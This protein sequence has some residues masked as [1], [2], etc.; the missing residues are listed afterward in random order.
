MIAWRRVLAIE[1]IDDLGQV[2]GQPLA[3]GFGHAAPPQQGSAF[4]DTGQNTLMLPMCALSAP[5]QRKPLESHDLDT[6]ARVHHAA[7]RRGGSVAARGACAAADDAGDRISRCRLAAA[8][9]QQV[10]AFR[11]GLAE[12]GYQ[13]GQNVSLE[14]RW[15]EGQY[16]RFGEL[17]ADLV[18]RRVSVIVTPGSAIAAL[19]VKA[20]TTTIPIV[21]GVG[22]DP[23]QEGLVTSL[24]RPGGNVTGVNFFTVEV[25][26]KRMQLLRE[27]VPAA[28]RIVVLVNPTDREGYQTLRDVQA[29]VGGEQILAREVASGRDIDAAFAD[30]AGEKTDAVFVGPG[31]FFNT[32]RVQLAVLTARYALPA[33]YPTRAYPEAGGL[34]SYGADVLDAFRQVG[35]YTGRIL[36]GAKPADLPVLQSIKFELVINLNTARALSLD[37][38]PSLLA[39]A[40][41]VIE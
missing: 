13:E 39:R 41:E 11:K 12:A 20:A 23:V 36:K 8:R 10:A 5:R 15:A 33:A 18:R 27:L 1:V 16:A 6:T 25:V 9:T 31:T 26:A 37:V 34:M 32:R 35:V 28:K 7:R 38:P 40:D 14:F 19:A 2:A 30:M 3:F 29:A 22:G 17:V 4:P 24:N 21:F